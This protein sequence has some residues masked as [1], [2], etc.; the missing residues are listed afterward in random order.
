MLSEAEILKIYNRATY[1]AAGYYDNDDLYQAYIH[2]AITLGK[3]L[4]IGEQETM[5]AIRAH[6]EK[7]R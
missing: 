6:L 1:R 7:L 4:E 3:I 2:N 5:S